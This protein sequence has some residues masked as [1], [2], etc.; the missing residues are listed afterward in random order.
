[1]GWYHMHKIPYLLLQHHPFVQ[2]IIYIQYLFRRMSSS[3]ELP[4]S[5]VKDLQTNKNVSGCLAIDQ[6]IESEDGGLK[7]IP[8]SEF[9]HL[10]SI[11]ISI[12]SIVYYV[13]HKGY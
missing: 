5:D 2:D 12:D 4:I 3:L 1:M 7:W 9:N 10:T 6:L 8:Y 11:Q 13:K